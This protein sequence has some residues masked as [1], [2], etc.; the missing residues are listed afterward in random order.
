MMPTSAAKAI[1]GQA[2][3]FEPGAA[4]SVFLDRA[5]DGNS[6]LRQEIEELISAWEGVGDFLNRSAAA[7]VV[8][9]IPPE[10]AFDGP[11][12]IIGRYR[13]LEQIGDGGMG[14]VF[15]AEQQ[16][17]MRRR[18]ALKI[19]KPGMD[20]RQMLARFDAE[21]H[22]LALMNHPN[23]AR[24]LDAGVTDSGRPYFVMELVRGIPI[25]DYCDQCNLDIPARLELFVHVCHA[26]QHAHQNG[27]IH[28]DIKPSNVLVTIQDG[29]GVPKVID[30]G[31][32]KATI[33]QLTDATS[34]TIFSHIIGTP[35][36]MSPEQAEMSGLDVDTRSDIYSL[37]VLLYELLTGS[38][39]FDKRL[40]REA[41]YDE[42]RRIIREEE[43][44]APSASIN[45]SDRGTPSSTPLW[46]IDRSSYC[47][48]LRGDLDC[49]VMK[50][51][52][53]ERGR[54]YPTANDLVRDIQHYLRHEPVEARP[55]SGAYR[56][57]KFTRRN[58]AALVTTA[59]VAAALVMG[60]IGSVWQAIRARQAET[61]AEV[62]RNEAELQRRFAEENFHKARQAVDDYVISVRDSKRLSES[63]DQLLRQELMASTLTYYRQF[64]EQFQY[65]AALQPELGLAYIRIGN[66]NNDIGLKEQACEWTQNGV[67]VYERLCRREPENC[68][69]QFTFGEALNGLATLQRDSG[70]PV[71]SARSSEQALEIL[72]RLYRD[73]PQVAKYVA[74]LAH[75]EFHRFLERSAR[76]AMIEAE[77]SIRRDLALCE[78]LNREHP[79]ISEFR[80]DLGRAHYHFGI[81]QRTTNRLPDAAGSFRQAGQI[82]EQLATE[83]GYVAN[84]RRAAANSHICLGDVC[85]SLGCKAEAIAAYLQACAAFQELADHDP[86]DASG[87][88]G[89]GRANFRIGVLEAELGNKQAAAESWRVA[90]AD[91]EVAVRQPNPPISALAGLAAALAMQGKWADAAAA[92]ERVVDASGRS[93]ESLTELALLQ[94]AADDESGYRTSCRELL[95]R[96]GNNATDPEFRRIIFACV[97]GNAHLGD[98][99]DVLAMSERLPRSESGNAIDLML[100]ASRHGPPAESLRGRRSSN[101][102]YR[103][104]AWLREAN[105]RLASSFGPFMSWQP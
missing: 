4:R 93:C 96:F 69:F 49:I 64:A 92:G 41:A 46:M 44:L 34:V 81:L 11:G 29:V 75:A 37:G 76:H 21:R 65:D 35:S 100:L 98:M 62:A 60:T 15:M 101:E 70:R 80:A 105:R 33:G 39:P 66:I 63:N 99:P 8:D 22:A 10:N 16:V 51:L 78:T 1:F 73:H 54:R 71:E 85:H 12:T 23:I 9:G 47:R 3:D 91:F 31:V 84:Y 2:V 5:C 40:L 43:P 38:P 87:R 24:A 104:V 48:L 53:K 20:T 13:L 82:Y 45:T 58:C 26:V 102:R 50:A 88:T 94:W 17:P 74:G 19:I 28:R 36:Y 32:A 89:V 67:E 30:F 27:I 72:E 14:V 83:F 52:E 25:T 103:C 95:S 61:V 56:F 68:E 55:P 59:L 90:V 77:T 97:A 42:M 86:P 6:K 7:A 57:Q 79:G 18:V